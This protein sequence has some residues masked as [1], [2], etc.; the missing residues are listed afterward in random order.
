MVDLI[1][2]EKATFWGDSL[3]DGIERI[4]K[5]KF[6]TGHNIKTFDLRVIEKI[7]EGLVT[8]DRSLVLD[9]LY[10]SKALVKME[11]HKL[12]DWGEIL[13]FPKMDTPFSFYRWDPRMIPYCENDV[14]LNLRVFDALLALMNHRHGEKTPKKWSILKEY[15]SIR[16]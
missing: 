2:R 4:Q 13:E 9:T 15:R 12:D 5:A 14:E 10:L 1:T 3:A 7:T 8:I 16:G 11:S 6:I